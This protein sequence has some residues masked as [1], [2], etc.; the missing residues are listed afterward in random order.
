MAVQ[1]DAAMAQETIAASVRRFAF[2]PGSPPVTASWTLHAV[3]GRLVEACL[4]LVVTRVIRHWPS[5]H[6]VLKVVQGLSVCSA[7]RGEAVCA[8]RYRVGGGTRGR[9]VPAPH[10]TAS[11]KGPAPAASRGMLTQSWPVPLQRLRRRTA[12]AGRS[13]RGFILSPFIAHVNFLK[14]LSFSPD[15]QLRAARKSRAA[16]RREGGLLTESDPGLLRRLAARPP[17]VQARASCEPR[18][19]RGPPSSSV[20]NR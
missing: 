12:R 5:S 4:K 9:C 8:G 10:Q 18:R 3:L 7:G 2:A 20:A 13:Y 17:A 6:S 16:V 1:R 15:M 11:R 14:L 19:W